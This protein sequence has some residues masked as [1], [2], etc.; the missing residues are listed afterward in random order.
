MTWFGLYSGKLCKVTLVFPLTDRIEVHLDHVRVPAGNGRMA[1]M[2][3]GRSFNVLIAIK[4]SIVTV[5]ATLCLAHA[6]IIAI[7]KVNN[8]PKYASYRDKYSLKEPVKKA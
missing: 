8:D 4:K 6:L 2:T 3:K 5:K 1:E 7:A